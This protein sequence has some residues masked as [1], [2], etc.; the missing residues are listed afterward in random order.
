MGVAVG[1]EEGRFS[2]SPEWICTVSGRS[3][4]FLRFHLSLRS[5]IGTGVYGVV[6]RLVKGGEREGRVMK[7]GGKVVKGDE[8]L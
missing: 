2:R 7:G 1:L 8:G 3:F 6:G 5:A 4:A